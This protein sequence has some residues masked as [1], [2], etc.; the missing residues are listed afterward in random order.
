[1]AKHT[2][3]TT[4]R[5]ADEDVEEEHEPRLG[6]PQGL[7]DLLFLECLILNASLVGTQAFDSN[8]FFAFCDK[9]GPDQVVGEEEADNDGPHKGDGADCDEEPLPLVA[10]GNSADTA[11]RP[12]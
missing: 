5:N 7:P 10:T 1:M 8:G 11:A 3:Q 9:L 12:G 2:S 6:I 4:V